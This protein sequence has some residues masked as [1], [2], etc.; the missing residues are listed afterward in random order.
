MVARD[1]QVGGDHYKAKRVQPWDA[2]EAWMT[3]E[4][5]RGYLRGNIIKYVA[6]YR[7]KGGVADLKKLR[8]YA[9]KLIEVEEAILL[10]PKG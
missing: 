4:E 10:T 1:S 2:M 8:H 9:D 6:R 7:D 5:F 3:P